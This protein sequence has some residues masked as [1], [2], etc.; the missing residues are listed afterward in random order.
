MDQ[1][2]RRNLHRWTMYSRA[3]DFVNFEAVEG[4]ILEFGVFGGVSLALLAQAHSF[5]PKGM[6]RR[7]VG[8]DSFRGLPRSEETHARWKEG[9]CSSCTRGTPS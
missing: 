8:Y 7:I 2:I 1:M 3:V 6:T 9:D 5:D 4:D